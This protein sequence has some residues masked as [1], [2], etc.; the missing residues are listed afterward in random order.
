MSQ[1]V[2]I[3]ADVDREDRVIGPLTARQLALL[4]G[5][6]TL[7][8]GLW[9]LTRELVPLPVFLALATPIAVAAVVVA[10]GQ[11]DG[12]GLDR[13]LV[14]A[15]RH[16]LTPR[17]RVAAPEG[18]RPVPDWLTE[19]ATDQASGAT[20]G[21]GAAAVA[22]PLELPATGITRTGVVDLGSDG[23]ALV[24]ACSPVNFALRTPAEQGAVVAAF[25]RWLH[26]LSAPAQILIRAHRLDLS[27]QLAE[28]TEGAAALPHP[29][30]EQAARE[31]ASFVASLAARS[32]LL[33][34]QI[35][36]VLREP[37][38]GP[39]ATGGL[40]GPG[41]LAG[42]RGAL[43]R[44]RAPAVL[45]AAARQAAET[46]LTRR[47]GEAADLLGAAG[48]TVTALDAGQATAVLAAACNPDTLLPPSAALAGAD[49]VITTPAI[50]DAD[51]PV[52]HSA[53][54]DPDFAD[55]EEPWD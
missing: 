39:S 21:R 25:G 19:P 46:R 54:H 30:L 55:E 43:G 23:L 49:E 11:R 35:L 4:A 10:L 2:K 42:L 38:G 47:L 9:A 36:L 24:A 22:A 45:D 13:L 12:V 6:G 40:G 37:A 41:G 34:R 32:D 3:P 5:A 7:L 48:V 53:D 16:R 1:P 52:E 26:A 8:Y 31:H 44:R 29:A 27:P 28:L 20:R 18:L 17:R 33:R 51:P 15:I 50:D 14:A